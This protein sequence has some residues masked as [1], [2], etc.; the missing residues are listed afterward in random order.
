LINFRFWS[1]STN[2]GPEISDLKIGRFW[3]ILR[4]EISILADSHRGNFRIEILV[5]TR[6]VSAKSDARER[7]VA[8]FGGHASSSEHRLSL[9]SELDLGWLFWG[10]FGKLAN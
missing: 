4:S 2:G 10:G 1:K 6:C 9:C 8:R 5:R 3:S 7:K